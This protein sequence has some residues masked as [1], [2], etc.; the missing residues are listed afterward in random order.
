MK[1][2]CAFLVCVI[3]AMLGAAGWAAHKYKV[4]RVLIGDDYMLLADKQAKECAEGGGC[5]IVSQREFE[6]S[7]K[8]LFQMYGGQSNNS[9]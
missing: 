9:P 6:Q 5:A 2:L 4:E 1:L 7:M 3:L 8:M